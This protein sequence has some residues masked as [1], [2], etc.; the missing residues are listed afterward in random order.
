ML[1]VNHEY[2]RIF[3][4]VGQY[5]SFTRAAALLGSNQP[6][7]T[8]SMNRLEGQLGCRLLVRTNRGVTLTPEGET[9]FAR[10]CAAEEQL[11]LAEDALADAAGLA[12]G[13]V[14][15]AATETA[16]NI[17]LLPRLRV[18]HTQYPGIRLRILNCSTPQAAEALARGEADLAVATT[19]V[20]TDRDLRQTP[21]LT[22]RE[23]LIGAPQDAPF[24]REAHTLAQL[25][26]RPLIL[27]GRGTMTF[28]FY[29]AL[30]LQQGLEL[31]PD[32]EA[33]TADQIL[34]LVKAG[35][36]LAFLPEAMAADAV[37]R[38]E[39]VRIPLQEEIP[40]REV[41]LLRSTR[42]PLSAPARAFVRML[43]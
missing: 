24:A 22:F 33:A 3:Y 23:V 9:L 43:T 39:A 7:V 12:Q 40:P 17:F 1:N 34:P 41:C 11:R 35:L 13:C 18:F 30:F 26:G 28:A 20:G 36:G 21:L 38:G 27:L 10:V 16:L 19:P 5:R 42:R 31:R 4:Y 25:Q 6:N 14:T 8:R 2:Y 32:T 37:C 15:I 29:S